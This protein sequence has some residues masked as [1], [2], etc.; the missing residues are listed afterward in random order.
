MRSVGSILNFATTQIY[1]QGLD[2][3]SQ[4]I[5]QSDRLT[6][7]RSAIQQYFPTI[8]T[9][10]FTRLN[11]NPPERFKQRFV[12]FYHLVSSRDQNGLG[13]DFF[14]RNSD[15]VQDAVFVP[16]YLTIILPITQQIARPLERKLAVISLTKTLTDSQ[17]FAVKYVKGWSKTC[18]ALLKLLENPPMP[19]SADDVIVEADVEDLSFGVGFTQLNV[20]KKLPKDD[21]PEV[22][23]VKP[24]VGGFLKA[25]D[26]RHGGA[27][28]SY[29]NERLN[30]EAKAVLV[31][32]M[33]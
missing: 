14:I 18:E 1:A 29:V 15:A 20:C 4:L 33:R 30:P 17:A 6:F 11:N 9:I 19:V 25:A 27:I 22:T 21:W 3:C 26:A 7:P 13:A 12:K 2:L 16:V 28:G 5:Q 8:L 32:Y 31:S 24:W 10:L 23:D